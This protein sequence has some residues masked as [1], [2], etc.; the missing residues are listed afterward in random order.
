[1]SCTGTVF[2]S[3]PA[4][5]WNDNNEVFLNHMLLCAI[6]TR[7]QFAMVVARSTNGGATWNG[8]GVIRT[9][10][11]PRR[12]RTRTSTSSTTTRRSPYH[13]NHYTCWDRNNNEKSAHSSNNGVSWTE[14]DLPTAAGRRLR[15]GLRPGGRGQRHRAR[16]LRH[17]DLRRQLHQRADVLHPLDQRRRL[18]VDARSWCGT[19]TWSPSRPTAPRTPRTT[20]ASARS[21]PSTWT[22]R[23]APVT[24]PS[25]PPSPTSRPRRRASTRPTSTCPL[26]QRRRTLVLAG[27]GQRR[28]PVEPDP[29]PPL[30]GGRPVER[31][32]GGRLARRPERHGQRRGR[33]LH[34]PLDRLRPDLPDQRPGVRRRAP[35]STTARS[36]PRT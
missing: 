9:A 27:Q 15:P 6:G 8:Q 35:S 32:G 30:P 34:L 28:R 22:T 18:L 23:A 24:A 31:P 17:P 13:G 4:V 1:M 19:S 20:A 2:G 25:T 10:G 36:R 5:Y 29:V 7:H 14:V 16:G 12:S 21:A 33:L 11:A 26:D 3:D